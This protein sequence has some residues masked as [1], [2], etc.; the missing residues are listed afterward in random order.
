MPGI[1]NLFHVVIKTN[2]LDDTGVTFEE[3]MPA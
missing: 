2:K 3:T 1:A